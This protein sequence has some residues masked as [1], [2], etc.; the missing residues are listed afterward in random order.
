MLMIRLLYHR[1]DHHVLVTYS[2]ALDNQYGIPLQVEQEQLSVKH[3]F[4]RID[5]ANLFMSQF[6]M[7]I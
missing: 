2:I 3:I 4:I 5:C 7:G 6:I 1:M